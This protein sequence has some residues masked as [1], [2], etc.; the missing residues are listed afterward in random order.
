MHHQTHADSRVLLVHHCAFYCSRF[1]EFMNNTHFIGS[2]GPVQFVGAD[3]TGIVD[4]HQSINNRSIHI[5]YYTPGPGGAGDSN[6]TL[7]LNKSM[8]VW[9]SG[10]QPRDGRVGEYL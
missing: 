2:S 4:I 9:P 10:E 5:G 3:R 8:I 6:G 1:K 7:E